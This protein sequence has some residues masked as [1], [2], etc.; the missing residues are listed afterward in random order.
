MKKFKNIVYEWYTGKTSILT[1]QTAGSR[2]E[3]FVE[4]D[5]LPTNI[6]VEE[7]KKS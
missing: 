5:M 6:R 3:I 7:K 1:G 2:V 4:D